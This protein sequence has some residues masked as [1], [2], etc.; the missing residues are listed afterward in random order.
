MGIGSSI[1]IVTVEK[2]DQRVGVVVRERFY[3]AKGLDPG[4]FDLG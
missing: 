2:V 4:W 3:P 1:I